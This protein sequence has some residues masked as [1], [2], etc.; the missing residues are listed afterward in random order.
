MKFDIKNKLNKW[1]QDSSTFAAGQI[2]DN[3]S[4]NAQTGTDASIYGMDLLQ[5]KGER[6]AKV[7]W[8]QGK[9]NLFEYI[10]QAKFMR[11]WANA[12]HGVLDH[13]PATDT[14]AAAGGFGEHTAPDDFRIVQNGVV[15]AFGQAKV[16]NDP[17]QTAVNFVNPKYFGM[18]RITTSDTYDNVKLSL[19]QMRDKGEIS[20]HAYHDAITHLRHGLTDDH[21]GITTGGTTRSELELFHGSDGKID[22]D[23]VHAYAHGFELDQYGVEIANRT[24]NGVFAGAVMRSIITGTQNLF[25]VYK[26]EKTLA[27]A[28]VEIGCAATHGAKRG[29]EVG[30]VAS[31]IRVAGANAGVSLL[32]NGSAATVLAA[33]VVDGGSAIY[34]YGQGK[35]SAAD[36]QLALRDTLVK[37]SATIYFTKALATTVGVGG[38]VFLPIAIYS[39][40]SYVLLATR[41][42]IKQEKLEA[43]TYRRLTA[44]A[45]Q[46][47][48]VIEDYRKQLHAEFTKLRVERR[49]AMDQFVKDF[50]DGLFKTCRYE[51]GMQALVNL[52]DQ[53]H[54]EL[55]YK[56]FDEFAVAMHDKKE[57]VLK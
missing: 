15:H 20:Q 34:A 43:E 26:D 53:M 16:N 56:D 51:D 12:G 49:Q 18:E 10:E 17:H 46:A 42:I 28:L 19:E 31:V 24:V 37:S 21:T 3:V 7:G 2:A 45:E 5:A 36:L 6:L 38:G 32:S 33:G 29:A 25:A 48:L 23:A 55:Q 50:D 11:N 44:L 52:A 27:Q 30:V 14:P 39:T 4:R 8:E 40:A 22:V 54:Y 47:T 1:L 57:F 9:G 35:I 13:A 41:S